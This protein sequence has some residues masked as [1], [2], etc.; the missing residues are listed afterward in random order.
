MH[1]EM[2]TAWMAYKVKKATMVPSEL[3]HPRLSI[4]S[5]T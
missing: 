2:E 5:M 4:K 3:V 1:L